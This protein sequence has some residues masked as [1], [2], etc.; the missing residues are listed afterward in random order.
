MRRKQKSSGLGKIMTIQNHLPMKSNQTFTL[1]VEEID[2]KLKNLEENFQI[3]KRGITQKI[4]IW[5]KFNLITIGNLIAF[6]T[7]LISQHI[8]WQGTL[9]KGGY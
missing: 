7:F 9:H 4:A 5:R 1:L 2:N 6:K 8:G 3:R